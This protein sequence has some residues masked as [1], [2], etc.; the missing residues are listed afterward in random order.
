MVSPVT[1]LPASATLPGRRVLVTGGSGFIGTRVVQALTGAGA[2][3]LSLDL[4]PPRQPLSPP[5]T[6]ILCD[7]RGRRL[8]EIASDFSPSVVV[9]LAA[10]VDV[11]TAELRPVVDADINVVGT[12]TVAEAAATVGARLVFASSCAVFGEPRQLPVGEDE[13][14]A[15]ST[16]YGLSKA[17]AMSTSSG[18]R[19]VADSP[20]PA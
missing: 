4:H 10:Q 9:H 3:V 16:P 17:A 6:S 1:P 2:T 5:A 7:I 18:S 15:P 19:G 14:I 8:G 13:P 12:I 20:P 11:T